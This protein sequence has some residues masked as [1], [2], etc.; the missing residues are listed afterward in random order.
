MDWLA[1][2]RYWGGG[3]TKLITGISTVLFLA[4][5]VVASVVIILV[6]DWIDAGTVHWSLWPPP[7]VIGF[8]AGL[9]PL[10]VEVALHHDLGFWPRN[11]ALFF[12]RVLGISLRK[13]R[14]E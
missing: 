11:F 7:A 14:D 12:L 1:T 2:Q 3:M 6:I 8:L 9:V 10:L 5:Y 13:N 4:N